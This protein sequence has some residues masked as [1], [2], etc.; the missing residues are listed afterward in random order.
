MFLSRPCLPL[1][2]SSL[3][4]SCRAMALAMAVAVAVAAAIA[5]AVAIAA[6]VAI[7]LARD[8]YQ[9]AATHV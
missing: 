1:W 6:A 9:I 4:L 5:V 2:F 7:A 8:P 3:F